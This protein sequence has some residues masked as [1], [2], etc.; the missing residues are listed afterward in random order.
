MKAL[1]FHT[2]KFHGVN[3][4]SHDQYQVTNMMSLN[5]QLGRDTHHCCES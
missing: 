4:L 5:A 3:T 2:C 1:I